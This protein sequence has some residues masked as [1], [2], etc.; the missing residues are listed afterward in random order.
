MTWVQENT[1]RKS[2]EMCEYKIDKAYVI[3]STANA[4][5]DSKI[6][7]HRLLYVNAFYRSGK[8]CFKVP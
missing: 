5:R 4:Q 6:V 2:N 7:T 1:Q 3:I 8:N